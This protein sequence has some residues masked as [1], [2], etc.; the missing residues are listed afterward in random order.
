MFTST[1][2]NLKATSSEAIIYGIAK[3]K[4]LFTPIKIEKIKPSNKYLRYS[5]Q[6]FA[7]LIFKSFFSDFSNKE[8]NEIVNK[9]Y[10]KKNFKECFYK[11]KIIDD[12]AFLELYHGNTYAF[13]DMAL[14]ALPYFMDI[15]KKKLKLKKKIKIVVAT[16]GDTGGAVLNAFHN[17]KDIEVIVLYPNKGVSNTQENQMKSLQ[18]SHSH[19]FA[20]NGNFDDCQRVVKELLNNQKSKD[21]LLTSANS[22]NIARLIPQVVYYFASYY[23]LVNKKFIKLNDKINYSVPTGNF[24]D[25]LAG[26]IAKKMGLPIDK[27]IC[28]SNENNVLTDFF[29]TGVYNRNRK[30]YKTNSPAMDILVSSNLERLLFLNSSFKET[31]KYM[32]LL[33]KIGK[34][35]I[36]EQLKK[37]L[38]DF[39]S[40]SVTSKQTLSGI[41]E[42][43]SS[44]HY[45][46]DPHTAVSYLGQKK[47]KLKNKTVVVST[48]SP[49]K[50][51]ETVNQAT[52]KKFKAFKFRDDIK[53]RVLTIVDI[54]N[55]LYK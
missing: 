18:T 30:F 55:Y 16:S 32:D 1:R 21:V 39:L 26:Y 52:G 35:K 50:F 48:A 13:K 46:I 40:V 36:S 20:L 37:K 9:A 3:D 43:Y 27:L 12:L 8:I 10:N 22:I 2:S 42:L 33:D 4:G 24:G 49:F 31:K 5:Y 51:V 11:A 6:D 54:K 45:L 41:K 14:S 25:I 28:A 23:D 19:A 34:Y 38:K 44:K 47:F 29:K 53:T 15:A 7:K 17:Y